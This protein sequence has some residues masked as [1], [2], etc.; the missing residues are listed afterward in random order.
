MIKKVLVFAMSLLFVNGLF[1]QSGFQ[2]YID[3]G[4]SN[5]KSKNYKGAISDFDNALKA[6]PNDTA[7]F[8]GLIKA[9]LL[10]D[11]LKNAQKYIENALSKY[12]N[13]SEYYLRRG[14]LYNKRGIFEKA[15]EDFNQ[16]IA[17]N[18]SNSLMVQIYLNLGAT[19]L[20]IEEYSSALGEYNK[21]M[22]LSPRNPSIYNYRGYANYKMGN[23]MDAINDYNNALDLD[24]NNAASYYNR[25][26]AYLKT[27]DKSKACIDFHK[28]CNIGNVNACKMIMSECS[29]K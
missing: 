21:A 29:A 5:L 19:E 3:S 27:S 20:R 28:A 16:A 18:P 1:A 26:M 25:G 8:S 14:I 2:G 23:F 17:K 15:I 9:Y 4:N 11:D 7:A 6:Q 24:P 12:P 22:E 10:S 13:N